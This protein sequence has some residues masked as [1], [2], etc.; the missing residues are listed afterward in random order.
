ML[1]VNSLTSQELFIPVEYMCRWSLQKNS[2]D[3]SKRSTKLTK[4]YY[5]ANSV[6]GMSYSLRQRRRIV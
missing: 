6:H 3:L 2:T 1:E 4:K 5:I